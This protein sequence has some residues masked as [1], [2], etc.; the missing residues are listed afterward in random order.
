MKDDAVKPRRGTC[1]CKDGFHADSDG[2]CVD[3]IR[4]VRQIAVADWGDKSL[5]TDGPVEKYPI[6]D[7]SPQARKAAAHSPVLDQAVNSFTNGL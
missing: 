4:Q 7:F 6:Y 2:I 3:R 1:Q 5:W